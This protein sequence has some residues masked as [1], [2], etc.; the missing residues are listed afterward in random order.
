MENSKFTI[1]K[2]K[3]AVNKCMRLKLFQSDYYLSDFVRE[4]VK[5][6]LKIIKY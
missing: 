2:I 5:S 6:S 3:H 4:N 1:N